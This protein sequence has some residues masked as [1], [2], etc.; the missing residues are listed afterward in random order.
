MTITIY[1]TIQNS[2]K[3]KHKGQNK[4]KKMSKIRGLNKLHNMTKDTKNS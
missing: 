3:I 1:R 4:K 2:I